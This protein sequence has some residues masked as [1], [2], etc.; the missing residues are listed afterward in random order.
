MVGFVEEAKVAEE[1]NV[2]G[3]YLDLLLRFLWI[4]I[5]RVYWRR[6]LS[7]N[8]F[9]RAVG[10]LFIFFLNKP[11]DSVV[12]KLPLLIVILIE[13]G[14]NWLH[15]NPCDVSVKLEANI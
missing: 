6:S 2:L 14:A 3:A 7:N 15:E 11:R 1:F 12:F 4:A 13:N 9:W 5:M 10:V 8:A